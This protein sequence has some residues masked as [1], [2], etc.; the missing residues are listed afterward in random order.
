MKQAVAAV[1]LILALAFVASTYLVKQPPAHLVAKLQGSSLSEWASRYP[2]SRIYKLRKDGADYYEIG[3]PQKFVS[4][5][6]P[7]GRA[8]AIFDARGVFVEWTGDSG[9]DVAYQQKW[10]GAAIARESIGHEQIP[11]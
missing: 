1:V 11:R 7:S 6:F 4:S 5:R 3:L 2:E 9:D 8:A 10:Q